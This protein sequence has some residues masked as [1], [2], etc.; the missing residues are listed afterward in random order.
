MAMAFHEMTK[1]QAMKKT[2]P[3]VF[4]SAKWKPEMLDQWKVLG[5]KTGRTISSVSGT[6]DVT[7]RMVAKV[8]PNRMPSQ[9][10]TKSAPKPTMEMART[11]SETGVPR[12][13]SGA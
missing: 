11:P 4:G 12:L 5:L 3:D 1:I 6:M 10:G 7:P 2:K 9:Q 8:A 13:P